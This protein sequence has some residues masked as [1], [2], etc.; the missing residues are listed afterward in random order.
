MYD[1][2]KFSKILAENLHK[3]LKIF[4]KFSEDLD[5]VSIEFSMVSNPLDDLSVVFRGKLAKSSKRT[6]PF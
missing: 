4:Q 2:V 1:F 3:T 6:W 5:N